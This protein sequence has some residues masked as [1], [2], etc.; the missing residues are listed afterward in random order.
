M[1][2]DAWTTGDAGLGL[3][4][5]VGGGYL[6]NLGSAG[7]VPAR[8]GVGWTDAFGLRG[9]L[10]GLELEY[11][12]LRSQ[13]TPEL[14]ETYRAA[15]DLMGTRAVLGYRWGRHRTLGRRRRLRRGREGGAGLRR[16]PRL[17]RDRSLLRRCTL[18]RPGQRQRRRPRRTAGLPPRALTSIP[19]KSGTT[20][21]GRT[22]PSREGARLRA[23]AAADGSLG[24]D[25]V[26]GVRGA[27]RTRPVLPAGLS[28][29]DR[30]AEFSRRSRDGRR[31]HGVPKA[32]GTAPRRAPAR[33]PGRRGA[34]AAA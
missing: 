9:F 10:L 23:T 34:P 32:T 24:P 25:P 2:A 22:A 28:W 16:R 31:A 26:P 13:V 5:A 12:G 27:R 3:Y 21:H 15:G 1:S 19:R 6:H 17:D 33:P 4:L 30:P 11:L 14:G 7:V 8:L 18:R 29:Q 20:P